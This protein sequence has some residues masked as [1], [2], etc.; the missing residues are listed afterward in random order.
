[1][2]KRQKIAFKAT[3]LATSVAFWVFT[4]FTLAFLVPGNQTATF[5]CNVSKNY[6]VWSEPEFEF[7]ALQNEIQSSQWQSVADLQI[8]TKSADVTPK[9]ERKK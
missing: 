8:K 3:K 5:S 9:E 6:G 7:G 4:A 1:M 2:N